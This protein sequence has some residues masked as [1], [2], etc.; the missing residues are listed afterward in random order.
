M[1]TT[2]VCRGVSDTGAVL[3]YS[4]RGN[5]GC[6]HLLAISTWIWSAANGFRFLHSGYTH[7]G[8][9]NFDA[10]WPRDISADGTT[11]VGYFYRPST[12]ITSPFAYTTD[13]GFL[14]TLPLATGNFSG[15]GANVATSVSADGSVIVGRVWT[16]Q[17]IRH[18][19]LWKR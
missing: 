6:S 1:F 9:C 14:T 11:I 3:G 10:V 7:N 13:V 18:P 12:G 4:S 2:F 16:S 5:S 15:V 19:A 8:S 17:T